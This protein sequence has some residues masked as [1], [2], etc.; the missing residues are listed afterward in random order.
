MKVREIVSRRVRQISSSAMLSEAADRMRTLDS[1]ALPVVEDNR[2]VGL[3]TDRDIAVKAA[4]AGLNLRIT[5]VRDVMTTEVACCSEDDDVEKAARIMEDNQV[6]RLVVLGPD[7][8]AVGILSVADL[9]LKSGGE[10]SPY[11]EL[12]T[13]CERT[14]DL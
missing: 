7:R 5:P 1:G 11:R 4:A 14:R 9:A 6:C 10:H 13:I 2:I 12:E 3:V 8:K